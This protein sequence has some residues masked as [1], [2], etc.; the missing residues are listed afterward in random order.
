VAEKIRAVA[1]FKR[2]SNNQNQSS[3]G[4]IRSAVLA[5]PETIR[6]ASLKFFPVIPD[7]LRPGDPL[8]Q[9]Y[10]LRTSENLKLETEAD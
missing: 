6:L 7:P 8:S 3:V 4:T 10:R 1:Q 5:G 2:V 9:V